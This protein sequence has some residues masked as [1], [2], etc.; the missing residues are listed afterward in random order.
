MLWHRKMCVPPGVSVAHWRLQRRRVAS[1]IGTSEPPWNPSGPWKHSGWM[2][3][4][5]PTW[6]VGRALTSETAKHAKP[7]RDVHGVCVVFHGIFM[8]TQELFQTSATLFGWRQ[9]SSNWRPWQG[10]ALRGQALPG[11]EGSKVC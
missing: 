8:G 3:L 9:R 7:S 5:F 10:W 1:Q 2:W 4:A 6:R 11:S